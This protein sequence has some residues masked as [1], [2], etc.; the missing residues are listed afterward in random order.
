M[1]LCLLLPLTVMNI[2]GVHDPPGKSIVGQCRGDTVIAF[3]LAGRART[4]IVLLSRSFAEP[5]RGDVESGRSWI[6]MI[7]ADTSD[8]ARDLRARL[9][10]WLAP[11]RLALALALLVSH[12]AKVVRREG[13]VTSMRATEWLVLLLVLSEVGGVCGSMR[14]RER[15]KMQVFQSIEEEEE[16]GDGL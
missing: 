14:G 7:G 15:M 4:G 5:R 9:G 10:A 1:F 8:V 2:I 3:E 12:R 13:M 6:S 16:H 11:L